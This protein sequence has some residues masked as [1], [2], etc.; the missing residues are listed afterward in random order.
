MAKI[1]KKNKLK[2]RELIQNPF[3]ILIS[4]KF[5]KNNEIATWR[6][7]VIFC[8]LEVQKLKTSQSIAL[9]TPGGLVPSVFQID[10]SFGR[11]L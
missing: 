3:I 2:N 4:T 6:Q 11:K 8:I 9:G 10:L 7:M 5:Y 1:E